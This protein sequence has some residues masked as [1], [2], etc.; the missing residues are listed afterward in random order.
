MSVKIK[1]LGHVVLFVHDLETMHRFYEKVLGFRVV[2]SQP[3]MVAFSSGRTHHELLLIQVGMR[4]Q[5]KVGGTPGLYHIGFKIGNTD[6]E[7]IAAKK[8]MEKEGIEIIGFGDHH[9]THSMYVLDP[10]GNELEL[11][12]DVNEDWKKDPSSVMAPTR[13]L[14]LDDE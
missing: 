2:G 7:L 10:E 6:K 3:G 5:P 11:Y 12:V 13:A 14:H 4:P 9:V 8:V 1:E